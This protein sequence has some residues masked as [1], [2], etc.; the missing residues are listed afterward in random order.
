LLA[1]GFFDGVGP[2]TGGE[3]KG[4][5]VGFTTGCVAVFAFAALFFGVGVGLTTVLG[6][7]GLGHSTMPLG[8]ILQPGGISDDGMKGL[9]P[10]GSRVIV[11][12]P[13]G[14]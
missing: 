2:G 5:G 4:F 1:D 14:L 3:A 8:S 10:L 12:L 6:T 11:C 7:I 9:E 13:C